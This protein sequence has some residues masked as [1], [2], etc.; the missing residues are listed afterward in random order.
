M[1]LKLH[2]KN[3]ALIAD[4]TIEFDKGFNVL[5]GET[6]AG[7]S[8]ILD[9]IMFVLGEK[10][11]K[12]NLRTGESKMS[13]QAIFD[14]ESNILN[15]LLEQNGIDIDDYLIIS[16]SQNIEGKFGQH[17]E[18]DFS[19]PVILQW[20][21]G[22]FLSLQRIFPLADR[23]D[24]VQLACNNTT[25]TLP[26]RLNQQD[27]VVSFCRTPNSARLDLYEH[28]FYYMGVEVRK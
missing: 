6:G 20:V 4:Q 17:G 15:D 25:S 11:S 3:F 1:L 12:L 18:N 9:A 19:L 7:K 24:S 16:R 23:S 22:S 8:L 14:N 5:V 26:C 21:T 28:P 10:A 2:I 27:I 13:V